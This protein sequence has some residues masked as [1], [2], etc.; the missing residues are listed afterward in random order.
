MRFFEHPRDTKPIFISEL[1]KL[2][3]PFRLRNKSTVEP[4]N[5][6]YAQTHNRDSKGTMSLWQGRGTE[7]LVG[8]GN[9]Q[10]RMPPPERRKPEGNRSVRRHNV[11]TI[12]FLYFRLRRKYRC[13]R[14]WGYR[15]KPHC[16]RCPH[17]REAPPLD[18]AKGT[19][20]LW[21]PN[22]WVC[23]DLGAAHHVCGAGVTSRRP[24][25]LRY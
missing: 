2:C 5:P 17:P 8:L 23:A 9:A 15:P 4:T 11:E 12:P 14:G 21:T 1:F 24:H 13:L 25:A 6:G 16:G 7:S 22:W 19:S 10:H 18:S 20:S 3:D